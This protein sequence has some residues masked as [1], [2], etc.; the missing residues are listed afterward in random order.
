MVIQWFNRHL[1]YD[2]CFEL[3]YFSDTPWAVYRQEVCS[4]VSGPGQGM[5]SGG[6]SWAEL[7]GVHTWT[8]GL[9]RPVTSPVWVAAALELESSNNENHNNYVNIGPAMSSELRLPDTGTVTG[10]MEKVKCDLFTHCWRPETS[11]YVSSLLDRSHFSSEWHKVLGICTL[12]IKQHSSSSH[13]SLISP[14]KWGSAEMLL[15]EFW[16]SPWKESDMGGRRMYKHWSKY[17]INMVILWLLS[18]SCV[19]IMYHSASLHSL[20]SLL[21]PWP[22]TTLADYKYNSQRILKFH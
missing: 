14:H 17:N 21:H 20:H 9:G 4:A 18:Q 8:R 13:H 6:L 3:R 15:S 19:S 11:K 7:W 10:K 2:S 5:G 12:W 22:H 1:R 16:R